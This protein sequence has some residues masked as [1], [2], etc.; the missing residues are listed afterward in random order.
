M[1]FASSLRLFHGSVRE[2]L[3]FLLKAS[4]YIREIPSP[5]MLF[6]PLAWIAPSKMDF[7]PS[8][9]MRAGSAFNWFP[10]PVQVGQAPKGLLKENIR[11]VSS[12]MEIPQSSQA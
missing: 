4:K 8:W 12:S 3:Y 10:R 9:I 5:R 11:G 6:Q 1:F 7:P 2:N